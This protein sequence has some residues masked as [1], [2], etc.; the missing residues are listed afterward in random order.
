MSSPEENIAILF[1]MCRD[2][3]ED[4]KASIKLFFEASHVTPKSVVSIFTVFTGRYLGFF[5]KPICF[6][7]EPMLSPMGPMCETTTLSE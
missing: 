7:A 2:G 5:L 6:G 1:D 3:H 4:G